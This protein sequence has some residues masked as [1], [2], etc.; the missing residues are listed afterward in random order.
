MKVEFDGLF[1]C[2]F[3]VLYGPNDINPK[4]FLDLFE[5]VFDSVNRPAPSHNCWRLEFCHGF[6]K[7]HKLY[8]HLG[9]PR[10]GRMVLDAIDRENLIDI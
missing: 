8:R 4:F 6:R 10:A 7:R 2:I 9:N 3:A 5:K 1:R